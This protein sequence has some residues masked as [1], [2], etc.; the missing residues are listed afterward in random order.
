MKPDGCQGTGFNKGGNPTAKRQG[1][2][3]PI[4]RRSQLYRRGRN[5]DERPDE[6]SYLLSQIDSW[7]T[8]ASL[9][10]I[11]DVTCS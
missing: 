4:C 10:F 3:E 6:L 8:A 11:K 9:L 1:S 2:Q 7:R 5:F